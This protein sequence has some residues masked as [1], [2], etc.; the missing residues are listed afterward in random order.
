MQSSGALQPA[1]AGIA[2]EQLIRTLAAERDRDARLANSESA[3][4]GNSARS[5]ERLVDRRNSAGARAATS[6]LGK[7]ELVVLAAE[8][9]RDVRARAVSLTAPT[10]YPIVKV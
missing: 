9:V 3:F 2:A 10:S 6:L 8:E 1:V 7:R 4:S 5:A